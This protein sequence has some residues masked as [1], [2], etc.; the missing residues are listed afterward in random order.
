MLFELCLAGVVT[1]NS[2]FNRAGANNRLPGSSFKPFV[3]H[4][5][6]GTERVINPASTSQR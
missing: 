6:D 5:R 1:P 2:Q 4:D 3:Y